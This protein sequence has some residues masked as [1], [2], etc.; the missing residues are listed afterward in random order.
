MGEKAGLRR[1]FVGTYTKGA[2]RGIYSVT[3]DARTGVLGAPELAAQA[4]NPTFLALSPGREFLYAVCAGPAWASSFR[5]DPAAGRLDPVQQEAPGAGPTPCHIAVDR[6]GRFAL[7]ANYHLGLAAAIPLGAGGTLGPPRVVAHT[8]KGPHPSRQTTAH[9]HST[10]F[11]PDGRFAAVCDLGLDRIYTYALDRDAVAL[12]PG[13][14]PFVSAAPGSGP[15]HLAFAADGRHA[16]A[17]NEL[18]NTIVLYGYESESGRLA[19]RQTV[20]VLP[21]GFEGDATA[22]EVAV[23]P[24]GRFL[25]GSCRGPDIL[26][27]F[28]IDGATGALSPV[29]SVPC[30]GRGPR[31][32]S[33]SPGGEWLVCAHQDSDTLCAFRADPDTGRLSR[34]PGTVPVPMPVCALFLD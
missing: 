34:V 14:P 1:L 16:Y 30:G 18:A 20:S 6:S 32:F 23:H 26:A 15:R 33:L 25:Y 22:A 5:V 19:P 7:A 29:E 8:G 28:A 31:H 12:T 17:I 4:P 11:A 27:V 21:S 24:N 13:N 10:N 2:S 9:V 3:L